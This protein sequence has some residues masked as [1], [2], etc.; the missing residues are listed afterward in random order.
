MDSLV[1][2]GRP[3]P[4]PGS[5]IS[6]WAWNAFLADEMGE[7]IC[8]QPWKC[9]PVSQRAER[10]Q[11]RTVVW[12]VSA[13]NLKPGRGKMAVRNGG[14]NPGCRCCHWVSELLS[15]PS[16]WQTNKVDGPWGPTCRVTNLPCF[17]QDCLGFALKTS[18]TRNLLSPGQTGQLVTSQHPAATQLWTVCRS[19]ARLLD[20]VV[21]T[22]QVWVPTSHYGVS[23]GG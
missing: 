15:Y 21:E 23:W 9:F 5:S 6:E 11:P 22:A 7:E 2:E 8:W 19:S 3:S 10:V 17:A 4:L 14:Q 18:Q 12:I 1:Y 16:R 13:V 20:P